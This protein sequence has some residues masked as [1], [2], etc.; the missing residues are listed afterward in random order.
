MRR[1][2][3]GPRDVD[4]PVMSR[5]GDRNLR[6]S[7]HRCGWLDPYKIGDC[8]R[9]V[10]RRLLAADHLQTWEIIAQDPGDRRRL[11]A[12][13]AHS[14]RTVRHVQ[15]KLSS[16]TTRRKCQSAPRR[17]YAALRWRCCIFTSR[18]RLILQISPCA[19][20]RTEMVVRTH[21]PRPAYPVVPTPSVTTTAHTA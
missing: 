13:E 7:R 21:T 4:V 6:S 15:R 8:N 5:A 19:M 12:S 2:R 18:E 1:R 11:L 16:E 20:C 9:S 10:R 14:P 17:S 3:A